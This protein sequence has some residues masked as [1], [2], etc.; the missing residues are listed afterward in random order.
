MSIIDYWNGLDREGKSRFRKAVIKVTGIS[1]PSFY[2]KIRRGSFT[3][4]E[5]TVILWL[6]KE[7]E[8]K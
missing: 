6:I 7:R 1:Y 4:C 5:E 3:L 8:E 2:T